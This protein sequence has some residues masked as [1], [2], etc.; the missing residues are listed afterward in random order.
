MGKMERRCCWIQWFAVGL[1]VAM[2]SSAG[3]LGDRDLCPT[4]LRMSNLGFPVN[5]GRFGAHREPIP[6]WDRNNLLLLNRG[7]PSSLSTV[8]SPGWG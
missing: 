7:V 6:V 4:A 5:S 2:V 3:H 8:H 1:V